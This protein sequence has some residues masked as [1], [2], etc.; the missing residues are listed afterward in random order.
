LG[1]SQTIKDAIDP[2]RAVTD[3]VTAVASI[4]QVYVSNDL[5][6]IK[7]YV[8]IYSDPRGKKTAFNNLK[9]LEG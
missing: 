9:K 4:T 5:Q 8:S 7:A 1:V 3:V 2:E 6:Y